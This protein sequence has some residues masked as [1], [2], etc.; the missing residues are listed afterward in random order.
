MWSLLSIQAE[1]PISAVAQDLKN[2]MSKL[3]HCLDSPHLDIRISAGEAI[4]LLYELND[5]QVAG[6]QLSYKRE[7]VLNRLMALTE[8][9]AKY[10]AKRDRRVQRATFRDIYSTVKN[11]SFST[12]TVKFGMEKL[13]LNS[14]HEK[15]YYDTLCRVLGV[16]INLHL[17]EN[18]LVRDCFQLGQPIVDGKLE[19]KNK[20]VWQTENA[21]VCRA[22][23]QIRSL[24]RRRKARQTSLSSS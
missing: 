9:S 6:F 20:A 21:S 19:K 18:P 15:L 5:E 17:K 8:D 10:H 12:V 14:W 16:G 13:E 11:S 2:D 1:M 4:G 7:E 3:C 22:R 24:Q 23:S